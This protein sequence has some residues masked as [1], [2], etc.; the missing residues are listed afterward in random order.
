MANRFF[1]G[2][3]LLWLFSIPFFSTIPVFS[4]TCFRF[5]AAADTTISCLQPCIDIKVRIPD[6]R[7]SEDYRVISIPYNPYPYVTTAPAWSHPCP[8]N[9]DDKFAAVATLPFNF[10]F[11]GAVHTQYVL[12]TN[13]V[14]TFDLTNA[15]KGNN[16][17][18]VNP[19]PFIGSG[20]PD[21]FCGNIGNPPVGV[22]YPKLSIMG[23]YQDLEPDPADPI[24]K[25]E[26]RVEG[27][28]PCRRFVMSYSK[29]K[30]FNS[31]ALRATFQ[32]VLNESTGLIDV[33]IENQPF[34]PSSF[35]RTIIGV[36]KDGVTNGTHYASPPSRN[37]F[38]QALSNEAWRFIPSGP[39]SLLDRVILYKNGV[40]VATADTVS[41]GNGELE[42][43]FKNVCQSEDSISY[44]VKAYYRSCDNP[45][46][47]TEGS[48]TITV[49]K[50]LSPV[51]FNVSN[52]KC[53]GNGLG[54]I[55]ITK[56]VAPNVEYSC[57]GGASWQ[58][59]PSFNL[60]SGNYTIQ[61]RIIGTNCSGKA[62]ATASIF[63]PPLLTATATATDAN[64]DNNNG[65][66]SATVSGGTSPYEY[67]LDGGAIF[68]PSN[69]FTGL[70]VG[71]HTITVRDANSCTITATAD[72][73]LTNDTM[74]LELGPDST[75]CSGTT[76]MLLPQT[77]N[78]TNVFNWTPVNGLNDATIKNPIARP[79]DTVK[80]YL[81]A[82]WGACQRTDSITINVKPSPAA[83][84]GNDTT[85]VIGSPHQLFATGGSNYS[86]SPSANL[87]NPLISN[88]IATLFNNTQFRV[89]VTNGYGC[90]GFAYINIKVYLGPTYYIPTAFTPNNDGLN[91]ILKFIPVG[92]GETNY[93]RVFNR[94]GNLVFQSSKWENGWDG[95]HN[96]T[97]APLGMYVWFIKGKD[98]DGRAIEMKGT[99]TLVR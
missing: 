67:A 82:K 32:V 49:F 7:T 5:L 51:L 59:S 69:M 12:G 6:I 77:N 78:A 21:Y 9:W 41:L 97:E 47:I 56:P 38:V 66:I 4:Q 64:C 15:M 55:T 94:W 90:T 11:Y 68:L 48:D 26:A 22:L 45:A 3:L 19:I 92:I 2:T 18:V 91:D 27:L 98:K 36:Q 61:A 93:F 40:Q 43:T 74:R 34:D 75:I 54:N 37:S 44:V 50:T 42:A 99:V 72:V 20:T 30:L 33:Y 85:A 62:T 25:I 88:P 52:P 96:G 13:G 28:A 8:N 81:T 70:P 57:N 83:F 29:V 16:Y 35:G 31:P 89:T 95:K 10:C 39:T 84:A 86:W 87:N 24:C 63:V 80:Y 76:V 23:A 58:P 73:L 1:R 79:R 46:I 65:T 53:Y 71:V 17:R 14:I 60:P